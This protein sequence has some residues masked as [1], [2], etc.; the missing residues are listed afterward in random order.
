MESGG[1]ASRL[2]ADQ[3]AFFVRDGYLVQRNVLEQ[4]MVA[5]ARRLHD[6]HVQATES[7][8]FDRSLCAEPLLLDML[9]RRCWR[10]AEQLVG[11]GTLVRP[12]SE[13]AATDGPKLSGGGVAGG[14]HLRAIVSRFRSEPVDP[15]L[16]RRPQRGCHVDAHP[17]SLGVVAYLHD[18]APGAGGFTVWP[19]THRRAFWCFPWQYSSRLPSHAP[20]A[21]D[22]G[23]EGVVKNLV[24]AVLRDTFPVSLHLARGDVV[25]F[26]HRL[27]HAGGHN[28]TTTARVA[29][30]YDYV[31]IPSIFRHRSA[32]AV[33]PSENGDGPPPR[34]MWEDWS[35]ETRRIAAETEPLNAMPRL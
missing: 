28:L 14:Q 9:P 5:A 3:I 27:M 29:V 11:P 35:T 6:Q 26:H 34:N 8:A 10:V 17:F 1:S 24:Q 13:P 18:V 4:S 20:L 31:K 12:S 25:Y 23:N 7:P 22:G 16:Q 32:L 30:F 21:G 15:G 33:P 19:G 2:S